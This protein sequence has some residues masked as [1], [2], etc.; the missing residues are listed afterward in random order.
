MFI[1]VIGHPQFAQAADEP[2]QVSVNGNIV[3]WHMDE[4]NGL[5][6]GITNT[7]KLLFIQM[8]DLS[9]ETVDI[10][11]APIDID[12]YNGKLYITTSNAKIL[13]VDLETRTVDTENIIY[14]DADNIAIDNNKIFFFK[15]T[16]TSAYLYYYD[17]INGSKTQIRNFNPGQYQVYYNANM[18][19]DPDTHILYIGESGSSG[20]HMYA[21]STVDFSPISKTN[22]DDDYGFPYPAKTVTLGENGVYYAGREFNKSNLEQITGNYGIPFDPIV[23]VQGN[24]VFSKKAIFDRFS[25]LKIKDLPTSTLDVMEDSTRNIYLATANQI[26]KITFDEFMNPTPTDHGTTDPGTTDPGT[27]DPGT[28]DPGPAIDNG[29]VEDYATTK[30]VDFKPYQ[31]TDINGHWAYNYIQNFLYSE[32]IKGYKEK[33]GT[34]TVRPENNITRAE[35]VAI[36]VRALGLTS[37]KSGIAFTDVKKGQWY[38]EPIRIAS[39]LGIVS[40]TGPNKFEPERNVTR[41]E[42][43]AM[44]IRAF[45]QTITKPNSAK[46]FSDVSAN[47]WA[48]P[49]IDDATKAGIISGYPGG[50]FKP[51]NNAKRAEAIKMLSVAL[52]AQQSNLPDN[53][54]IINQVISQENQLLELLNSSNWTGQHNLIASTTTGYEFVNS[55]NKVNSLGNVYNSG[56]DITVELIRDMQGTVIQKSNTFAVVQLTVA[57]KLYTFSDRAFGSYQYHTSNS[58]NVYLKKDPTTGEFEIYWKKINLSSEEVNFL[59]K[60]GSFSSRLRTEMVNLQKLIT[61]SNVWTDPWYN[62][63]LNELDKIEKLLDDM[64]SGYMYAPNSRLSIIDSRMEPAILGFSYGLEEIVYAFESEYIEDADAHFDNAYNDFLESM[65]FLTQVDALVSLN[66]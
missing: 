34:Y 62:S 66:K 43:S 63:M 53:T 7:S 5:I 39:S 54:T 40:G 27:T 8:N 45:G 26:E 33:N 60:V 13:V 29:P 11:G 37:N 3:K 17:P 47:H 61:S 31:P 30:A 55:T 48:K 35:V 12:M 23:F 6:Y 46:A 36:L 25:K 52:N 58:F 1:S 14:V 32:L 21:L 15:G 20:S 44:I 16:N 56:L 2:I 57:S 24:D 65:K 9:V 10:P 38:Y 19:V 64:D 51:A 4:E 59:N 50:L 28:N 22:Y 42:L 18:V 49:Y 41:A